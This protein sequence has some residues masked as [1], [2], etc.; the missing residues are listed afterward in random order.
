MHAPHSCAPPSQPSTCKGFFLCVCI[1]GA[2][3]PPSL[4]VCCLR[5][6]GGGRGG[7]PKR[8][9]TT[10]SWCPHYQLFLAHRTCA[11]RRPRRFPELGRH[12]C[13]PVGACGWPCALCSSSPAHQEHCQCAGRRD[14][15]PARLS[16]A[17]A[18]AARRSQLVA[19]ASRGVLGVGR[20][21]RSGQLAVLRSGRRLRQGP[22]EPRAGFRGDAACM[23]GF[24]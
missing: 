10:G 21:L 23:L 11:L 14:A 15:A 13:G 7:R 17:T 9:P 16:A 8:P 5:W 1:E 4:T 20:Q 6:G 22:A 12:A 19:A 3:W 2:R 18:A 24:G